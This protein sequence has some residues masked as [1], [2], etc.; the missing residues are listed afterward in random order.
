MVVQKTINNLKQ[1]P[2]EDK[3]VIAGGIALAVVT[4]LFIAWALL[5]LKRIQS[6]E[7]KLE[8]GGAI[9]AEFDFSSLEEAQKQLQQVYYDTTSE[10]REIRDAAASQQVPVQETSQLETNSSQFEPGSGE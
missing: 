9:P 1:R 8:L 2:E 10:L 7:Q 4:V 3:K 5:F 6:G